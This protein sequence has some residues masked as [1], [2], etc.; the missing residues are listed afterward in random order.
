MSKRF[1][2]FYFM[3]GDPAKIREVAPK[4]AEY[5]KSLGLDGYIGGPFADRSGGMITFVADSMEKA[6]NIV[7]KD[8]FVREN[9]IGSKWI[10]EW[11]VGEG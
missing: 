9:L 3:K 10:K 4:H 5:W 2:N 11:A 6:E 8:P 1:V 7:M